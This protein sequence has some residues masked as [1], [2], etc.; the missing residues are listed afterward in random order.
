VGPTEAGT[1]LVKDIAPGSVGS[2]LGSFA[3]VNGTLFLVARGATGS[4]L[5]K[6]DG[7]EVGTVLVKDLPPGNSGPYDLTDV[8]GTLYYAAH[9]GTH[10]YELW[11]SDGTEAGTVLVA[12]IH[13]GDLGSF[14][15]GLTNVNGTLFFSA[16]DGVHGGELWKSGGQETVLANDS[17]PDG[18]PLTA[19]LVTGPS[20]GTL[21]L[22]PDGTFSYR[23]NTGFTGT[24][25]FTYK[26]HD[27][28]LD[29][30]VA[31][32]TIT[33]TGSTPTNQA[34][35]LTAIGNQT[36]DEGQPLTFAAT[37]NDPDVGQTLTFSLENG[38][39]GAVPAGASINATTGVF[40]WTPTEAQ[41]P[42]TFTFDVVV[43][44]NGAPNLSDRETIAVTVGEIN[45]APTLNLIADQ[46]VTAGQLLTFTAV[47]GDLDVPA[48]TLTY[49]LEGT[50]PAGISINPTT[51]EFT[52]TPTVGQV[53]PQTVTVRV[54]D[55]GTLA[56]FAEQVVAIT[57][58][59]EAQENP[60]A[61][62]DGPYAATEDQL[63]TVLAAQGVLANDSDPNSDPLTATLLTQ[64]SHGLVTLA[65]N[66][67]FSYQPN[68][69]FNGTDSFTYRVSDGEGGTAT[70]TVSLTVAAVNDA[71]VLASI[72]N[73]TVNEQTLLQFTV[74]GSDVDVPAQNLRYSASGLPKRATFDPTTR[75]FT[76][77]PTETQGPGNYT[78]TFSVTDG[79]ASTRETIT[80]AV[81][82]VNVAPVLAPIATQS[83]GPGKILKFKASGSD[84]DVPKQTLLYSL[85]PVPGALYPTGITINA[86]TGDVTWKTSVTQPLVSYQVAVSVSDG[87]LSAAQVVTINVTQRLQALS[88]GTS[89]GPVVTSEN[90][91]PVFQEALRRW[92]D[93]ESRA[94]EA[95]ANWSVQIGDL[96]GLTLAEVRDHTIWLDQ[97]AAGHGWF[98]DATPQDNTE[99]HFVNSLSQWVADG[100]SPAAHHADLFTVV[101]HELG[102]V[103][104]LEDQQGQGPKGTLMTETLPDGVRRTVETEDVGLGAVAAPAVDYPTGG[105]PAGFPLQ[106]FLGTLA[107]NGSGVG[108]RP[109]DRPSNHSVLDWNEEEASPA[110]VRFPSESIKTQAWF[111]NFLN[112]TYTK[113]Q[114][115]LETICVELPGKK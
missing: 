41:G 94:A 30:N 66:G 25:S 49:S 50:I 3:N 10:G 53:G 46:A 109:S 21:T 90:I 16:N 65:S 7:T 8:N 56:L 97:T 74:S 85:A 104:G 44:D 37:A 63:L 34:P 87:L 13:T 61:Q 91:E 110:F 105:M 72:G 14:P 107:P 92:T 36:I 108:T 81:N 47:G 69:N 113:A 101:M 83:V 71:P 55:N 75:T 89:E 5:W 100:H 38:T 43:T 84:S 95:V 9:D 51:G 79:V 67:G 12:D 64:A 98:I 58:E 22:N 19:V 78:V 1:V 68:L 2:F 60:V 114:D 57:V 73:K 6:S 33:V 111:L 27:G 39:T 54:T 77:T 82:E 18:D 106:H 48:N 88:L 76:W 70:G 93:V 26:A 28:A 23:P 103:L 4:D 29:S 115:R 35:V 17:D 31:T 11:K 45:Q 62:D 42:G 86:S 80:I 24:D 15:D 102:H 96:D 32:V 52:W 40:T 112:G 20:N 59:A 99:F